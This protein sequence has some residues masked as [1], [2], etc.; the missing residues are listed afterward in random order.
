M[1]IRKFKKEYSY[2]DLI[3]HFVF[4][5]LENGD[6]I[7]KYCFHYYMMSRRLNYNLLE[8]YV[9]EYCSKKYNLQ[10]DFNKFEEVT[11]NLI[12]S[13]K[14][15]YNIS[16]SLTRNNFRNT[17][18]CLYDLDDFKTIKGLCRNQLNELKEKTGLEWTN[19]MLLEVSENCQKYFNFVIDSFINNDFNIKKNIFLR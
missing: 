11:E 10:I 16:K 9:L 8:Q 14:I 15:C 6:K 12:E 19:D 3:N 17:I 7:M 5:D 1:S 2:E 13:Y 4:E 18:S